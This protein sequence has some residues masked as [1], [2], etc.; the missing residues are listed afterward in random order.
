MQFR[1]LL[2]ATAVVLGE[3]ATLS[4]QKPAFEVASVKVDRSGGGG[5]QRR[6]N[7]HGLEFT[8]ST[9]QACIRWAYDVRDFQI[10]GAPGWLNSD[11]Y[12]I[13][14]KAA[15]NTST[16]QLRLMLQA[17]L[18]ERFK[19]QLHRETRELPVYSLVVGKGGAKLH[20]TTSESSA[21]NDQRGLIADR[22]ATMVM[23]ANQLSTVLERI[24]MDKTGLTERYD[25]ELEWAPGLEA[26]S[27]SGPS[28]FTA[29]QEQLG[30]KLES[31]KGEVEVLV[32]DHVE[33]VPTEN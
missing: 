21:A 18:E 6:L 14:A 9:L 17:L 33:R 7:G 4:G 25:F 30:L 31:T 8:N 23:L 26:D 10:S 2:A 15:A 3:L 28:V 19:L 16:P 29:I 22:G 12:G 1:Y 24:V 27:G 20:K 11:R 5:G 32:I 13:L